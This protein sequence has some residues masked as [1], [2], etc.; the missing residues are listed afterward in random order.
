MNNNAEIQSQMVSILGNRIEKL[1]DKIVNDG[2]KS[3]VKENIKDI[4]KLELLKKRR[5]EKV[6]SGLIGGLENHGK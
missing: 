4:M 5:E 1:H 6:Q 2:G 3:D